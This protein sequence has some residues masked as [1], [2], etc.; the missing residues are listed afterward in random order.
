M[1]PEN[2]DHAA[3]LKALTDQPAQF[4]GGK[5][6]SATRELTLQLGNVPLADAQLIAG[7]LALWTD[8]AH[9]RQLAAL[10]C[11]HAR[12]S[13]ADGK[14]AVQSMSTLCAPGLN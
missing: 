7:L 1:T 5:Y 13:L 6:N 2:T 14:I 4:A 3:A 8:P 12:L 9:E 10:K 11:G